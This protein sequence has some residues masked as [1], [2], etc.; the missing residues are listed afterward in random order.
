MFDPNAMPPHGPNEAES[1]DGPTVRCVEP[2]AGGGWRITAP[3]WRRASGIYVTQTEA[4]WRATEIVANA[5]G[6]TVRIHDPEGA[7]HDRAVR[8]KQPVGSARKIYRL[9]RTTSN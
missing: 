8:A 2:H 7:T 6:G 5:G 1:R 9:P 3:G 4:I